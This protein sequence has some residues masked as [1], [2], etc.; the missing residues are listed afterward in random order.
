MES[1]VN[2]WESYTAPK[3]PSIFDDMEYILSHCHFYIYILSQQVFLQHH[4]LELS[5]YTLRRSYSLDSIDHSEHHIFRLGDHP[6]LYYRRS[7]PYSMSK[8][9]LLRAEY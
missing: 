3:R 7:A 9:S 5:T 8:L 2:Q 6:N 1:T 4:L